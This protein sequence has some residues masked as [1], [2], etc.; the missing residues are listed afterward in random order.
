[1][2]DADQARIAADERH[3]GGLDG[4]VGASPDGHAEVSLGERRRIVDAVADH[5]HDLAIGLERS[6]RSALSP[7]RTSAMTWSGA[8]PTARATLW[9]VGRSVA[10]DQPCLDAARGEVADG[11]GGL[12]LDRGRR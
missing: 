2:A 10:G 1:M 6:N 8:M 5:G 11:G 12:R 7:G 3:V 4:D 9:A